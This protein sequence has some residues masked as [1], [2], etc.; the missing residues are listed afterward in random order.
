MILRAF[1]VLAQEY[2]ENQLLYPRSVP[3][4]IALTLNKKVAFQ[5]F[6][7]LKVVSIPLCP[8]INKL[9]LMKTLGSCNIMVGK[10]FEHIFCFRPYSKHYIYILS[11]LKIA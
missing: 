1:Q 10:N 9:V 8:I 11:V 2:P 4:D 3:K 7:L 5:V 6:V